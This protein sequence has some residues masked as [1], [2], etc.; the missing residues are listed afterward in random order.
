[1]P[2]QGMSNPGGAPAKGTAEY[3]AKRQTVTQKVANTM[4]LGNS[5]HMILDV[6][7]R[8]EVSISLSLLSPLFLLILIRIP[9]R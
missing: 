1:M 4:R 6:I 7:A 5:T 8:K 2:A 9:G 3:K